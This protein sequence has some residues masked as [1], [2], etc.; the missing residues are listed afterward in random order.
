M[1]IYIY[2][3]THTRDPVNSHIYYIFVC[4]Y[5]CHE[6]SSSRKKSWNNERVIYKYTS[7][8]ATTATAMEVGGWVGSVE[9]VKGG[10]QHGQRWLWINKKSFLVRALV[11]SDPSDDTWDEKDLVQRTGLF[12]HN[13]ANMHRLVPLL[14]VVFRKR[15]LQ[16]V[17]VLWKDTCILILLWVSATL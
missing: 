12:G 4:I 7:I 6:I 8:P 10:W 16:L 15:A 13:V 3:H 17:A 2:R 9:V 11:L 1:Y 5:V 14:Q